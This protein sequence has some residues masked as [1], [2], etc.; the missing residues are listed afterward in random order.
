MGDFDVEVVM[1][2]GTSSDDKERIEAA[3]EADDVDELDE[4]MTEV[5]RCT[6]ATGSA[7]GP[8]TSGAAS[9]TAAGSIPIG[10]PRGSHVVSDDL[11]PLDPR[12]ALRFYIDQRRSELSDETIKSHR[13]RLQKFVEW[14]DQQLISN[15]LGKYHDASQ[16]HLVLL[17][18]WRLGCR[19]GGLRA[20]DLDDDGRRPLLTTVHG[21]VATTTIRL[22]HREPPRRRPGRDP[23]GPDER[24]SR[25][26]R[27]SLRPAHGAREDG[28]APSVRRVEFM[29]LE[30]ISVSERS[31][32][33][34]E[35]PALAHL[36]YDEQ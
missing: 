19:T 25:C 7:T 29:K 14:C 8:R 27:R 3:V 2:R 34:G 18:L 16:D 12:S 33:S 15:Y 32:L 9:R 26:S 4:R 21:R 17:L 10:R 11:E 22:D 13:Y 24:Q 6:T 23:R 5:P 30:L 1:T 36:I 35:I 28:T 31:T 20:L